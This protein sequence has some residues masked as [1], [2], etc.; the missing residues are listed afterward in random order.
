MDTEDTIVYTIIFILILIL[1]SAIFINCTNKR[2]FN[3]NKEFFRTMLISNDKKN[4]TQKVTDS[5]LILIDNDK[6]NDDDSVIEEEVE[7][8][9][10][11]ELDS[12]EK[13]VNAIRKKST[14]REIPKKKKQT[15]KIIRENVGIEE[16][17]NV[18]NIR[19]K[20]QKG[21]KAEKF[22][23][24][25]I[26]SEW[27]KH[28]FERPEVEIVDNKLIATDKYIHGTDTVGQSLRNPTYDIRGTVANPKGNVGP[29][30]ISTIDVDDNI[31]S[32]C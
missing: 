1:V 28:D 27:F 25:E 13:V 3:D 24:K 20:E 10:V 23:P 6:D 26:N 8:E 17:L 22:L 5:N 14:I 11:S 2:V 12:D 32:W 4:T 29:W 30:N 16:P 31:K 21:F 7:E 18:V 15:V 9:V 19:K